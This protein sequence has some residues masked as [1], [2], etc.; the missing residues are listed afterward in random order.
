MVTRSNH[1]R[2]SQSQE[3]IHRVA[4]G[5]ISY[6]RIRVLLIHRRSFASKQVWETGA[7]SHKQDG[8][9]FIF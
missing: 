5:D 4:T 9:R 8:G 1:P 3:N 6:W 7:E 2:Q